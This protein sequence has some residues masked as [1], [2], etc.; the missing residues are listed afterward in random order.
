MGG[1][2]YEVTVEEDEEAEEAARKG[3]GGASSS[4]RLSAANLAAIQQKAVQQTTPGA[5]ALPGRSDDGRTQTGALAINL[6]VQGSRELATRAKGR[7]KY[8]VVL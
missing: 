8:F 5:K 1:Q 2:T 7:K 3:E 4:T 6:T